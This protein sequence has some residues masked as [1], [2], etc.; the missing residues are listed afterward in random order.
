[1]SVFHSFPR[2]SVRFRTILEKLTQ[3]NEIKEKFSVNKN[4]VRRGTKF[5]PACRQVGKLTEMNL[6][7]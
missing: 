3:I 5:L 1:M 7:C 4:L 6:I 2:D